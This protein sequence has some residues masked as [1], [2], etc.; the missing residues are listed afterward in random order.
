MKVRV[1][2]LGAIVGICLASTA[3][4]VD[5][6]TERVATVDDVPAPLVSKPCVPA[7]PPAPALRHG[8]D[9]D[10]WH[11]EK[12]SEFDFRKIGG[13]RYNI[14]RV[15]SGIDEDIE[16]PVLVRINAG[17]PWIDT[18]PCTTKSLKDRQFLFA[19]HE[20][21][22]DGNPA[23]RSWHALIFVPVDGASA[24]DEFYYVVLSI[25]N[26]SSKCKKL[27]GKPKARCEALR[28]LAVMKMDNRPLKKIVEKV[29]YY[30]DDILP[31]GGMPAPAKDELQFFYHN[32][33]IHGTF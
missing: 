21:E 24:T 31:V 6:P 28:E 16:D 20:M 8:H 7:P 17:S 26:D 23:T 27:T 5:D 18:A 15:S 2:A 30:I 11:L 33:V 25:E 4:A 19:L 32:G 22:E 1:E 13:I 3:M 9:H 29:I 10:F 12:D 14:S